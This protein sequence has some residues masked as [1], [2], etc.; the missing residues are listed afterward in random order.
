MRLT[1]EWRAFGAFAVKYLG[2]PENAMPFYL[3]GQK[4]ERKADKI[5][6]FILEVGNFGHNRDNSYYGSSSFMV[7]KTKSFGRRCG[8]LWRHSRIFPLDSIRFFPNIVIY[9]LRSAANG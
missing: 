6:S 9:G 4:W 5:C 7:R 8:D 3:S 1:T 2:M